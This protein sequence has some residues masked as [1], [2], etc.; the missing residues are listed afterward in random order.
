MPFRATPAEVRSASAMLAVLVVVTVLS[1]ADYFFG[2]R[3]TLDEAAQARSGSA[4]GSR[5]A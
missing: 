2:L 5:A 3:R 1:G 4:P